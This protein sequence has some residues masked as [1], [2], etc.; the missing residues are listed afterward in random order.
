MKKKQGQAQHRILDQ[1]FEWVAS[2]GSV[3][4]VL[5]QGEPVHVRKEHQLKTDTKYLRS[6]FSQAGSAR[7]LAMKLNKMFNT[8]DFTV[9]ELVVKTPY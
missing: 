1:H 5:C 4:T 2:T 7:L 8:T 3:W 6:H 9:A